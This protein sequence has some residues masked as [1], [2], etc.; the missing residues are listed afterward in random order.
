[1]TYQPLPLAERITVHDTP[2]DTG[3]P[4]DG[5]LTLEDVGLLS[6]PGVQGQVI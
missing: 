3:F 2:V 4:P 6:V 1:M 5:L